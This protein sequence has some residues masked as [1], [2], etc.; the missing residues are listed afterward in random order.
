ML[1]K[2][3]IEEKEASELQGEIDKKIYFLTM[4]YPHIELAAHQTR[5]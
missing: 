1:K 3:Q 2:G 4:H 5:I